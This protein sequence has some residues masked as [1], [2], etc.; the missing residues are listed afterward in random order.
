[1][2]ILHM[3]PIIGYRDTQRWNDY[4]MRPGNVGTVGDALT[5]PFLKTSCTDLPR[6][7]EQTFAGKR[8]VLLGSVVQ[9]G[10]LPDLLTG[11]L[12]ARTV[13]ANWDIRRRKVPIANGWRSQELDVPDV[14]V[15]PLLS[16]LGD[17][18]WRNK[19]AKVQD[20]VTGFEQ[21]PGEYTSTGIPRG[22]AVP[23]MVDWDYGNLYDSLTDRQPF[24]GFEGTAP[25][26]YGAK[27][28]QYR[29]VSTS[30]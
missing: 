13:D 6:R 21:V 20:R 16:S 5:T 9:N 8:S 23:R 24:Y 18:S 14:L 11:G 17:F 2:R 30:T 27:P 26:R 12:G 25:Q 7:K 1:M 3:E 28:P 19:L 29:N 4:V 10:T 22:G 15:E